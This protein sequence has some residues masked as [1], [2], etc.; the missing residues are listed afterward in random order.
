MSMILCFSLVKLTY[1]ISS[2]FTINI[3][4]RTKRKEK[5]KKKIYNIYGPV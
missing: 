4:G 3:A 5:K 2:D 1:T